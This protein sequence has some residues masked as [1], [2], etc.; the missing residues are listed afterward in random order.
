MQTFAGH[1]TIVVLKTIFDFALGLPIPRGVPGEI[2]DLRLPTQIGVLGRF[3]PGSRGPHIFIIFILALSSALPHNPLEK[4]GCEALPP[5]P[6]AFAVGGAPRRP[7][8][9]DEFRTARPGS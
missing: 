5:F 3:R 1:R 9:L 7:P 6:V 8:K 4:M 2:S